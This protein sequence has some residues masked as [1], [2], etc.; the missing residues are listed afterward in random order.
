MVAKRSANVKWDNIP[1]KL[2]E[3]VIPG[4]VDVSA[5]AEETLERLPHLGPDD[6]SQG[7]LWRD[8]LSFSGSLRTFSSEAGVLDAWKKCCNHVEPYDFQLMPESQKVMRLGEKI[9]WVDIGFTCKTRQ[10]LEG[11]VA[12]YVSL[13]PAKQSKNKWRIWMLRTWLENFEGHGHP[14]EIGAQVLDGTTTA[15]TSNGYAKEQSVPHFGAIVV[16][17]GQSGLGVAGRLKALG[18]PYLLIERNN[19]I[20]DN[21]FNRYDSVRWHTSKEYGHL[22]FDRTY[23][24]EDDYMLTGKMIGSGFK[25]WTE[26]FGI[27]MRLGTTVEHASYDK[28]SGL[29]TLTTNSAHSGSDTFT[30]QNLVLAIGGY[31]G[32]PISPTWPSRE[33]YTGT[34]M[35]SSAYKSAHAW[36][37]SRGIIIG[38]ANTAHDVAEDMVLASFKS[39]TMVQRSPTFVFPAE[40]LHAAEDRHYNTSMP[41]AVADRVSYTYPNKITREMTNLA[42][43]KAIDANPAR[44]DALEAVGFRLERKGDIYDN[45]YSRFGG[46]YVDIGTSARIARGEIRVKGSPVKEW[47]EK[48]LKFE[49]GEEIEA[50]LVVLCTG[51]E[52]DFRKMARRV[53]GEAAEDMDEFFGVD[54]EGEI[55]GA[56]KIAGHPKLYYT[57][58]DV[59]QC[60][61]FSRFIA[62]QIQAD[63]LGKPLQEI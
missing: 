3:A 10:P 43:H 36:S 16:G 56:W 4:D 29:W 34:A 38:T 8:Y 7:A 53:I 49:D 42:V 39:T 46:H 57:G 9:S 26:R 51:F 30:C 62:L 54:E 27:N 22:P 59:R 35:H 50:D 11:N 61:W 2:P 1:G 58:G 17:A 13:I 44:F 47:T 12:G 28:S 21:W 15:S 31:A 14:D 63:Y 25:R 19:E 23:L 41:T 24:P 60:R 6:L 5:L 37:G 40:W 18:V 52:K 48:G 33:K 20:G 45:L 55:R 32:D